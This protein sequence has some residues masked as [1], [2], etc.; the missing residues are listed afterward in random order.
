MSMHMWPQTLSGLIPENLGVVQQSGDLRRNVAAIADNFQVIS[1]ARQI[2]DNALQPV[3][4]NLLLGYC[5]KFLQNA[6]YNYKSF[7]IIRII[8]ASASI[9]VAQFGGDVV[10]KQ[11]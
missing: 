2:K 3:K 10:G 5:C 1:L 11:A 4:R 6:E 7:S 9:L 8:T